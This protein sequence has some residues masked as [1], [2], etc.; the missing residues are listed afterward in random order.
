MNFKTDKA[1]ELFSLYIRKRDKNTCV[2]CHRIFAEGERGLSCAHYFGR[3]KE[4]TRFDP[5]NCDAMCYPGCH[6]YWQNE[7]R[8]E[9]TEFKIKQLGQKRYDLLVLRAHT[10]KKK[11]RKMERIIWKKALEEL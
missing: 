7:A 10:T 9:Y 8:D 1:D 3:G 5:E 4:S 6:L 11:D 2:R